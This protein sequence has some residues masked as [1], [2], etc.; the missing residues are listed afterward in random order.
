LIRKRLG[1][2][3]G[4]LVLWY[5]SVLAVVLLAI[6]VTQALTLS[7]YLRS[8]TA[9][10]MRQAAYAELRALT[11]CFVRSAAD[12]NRRAQSLATLLGSHE[13]AV[14]IVTPTGETLADHSFG[15][16]NALHPLTLSA[17]T[18]T[19]LIGSPPS[20]KTVSCSTAAGSGT[21]G[22][23]PGSRPEPAVLSQGSLV[24]TSVSIGPFSHP[25]GYALLGRS[26]AA[27]QET[28][29]RTELVFGLGALSAIVLAALVALPLI[30]R[31]LRPLRRVA[32]TAA[33]IAAGDLGQ[34][35]NLARSPDEIGR[36]G[37]AFDTMVDRL[38]DALTEANESEE[39]MRRFLAD[40]S[41]EL[42]TP[43][44]VL[45][46]TSEVLLRHRAGDPELVA[47]L[48][49]MNEDA[50]RLSKLVDDLLT[51]TRL[52]AGQPLNPEAIP[53]RSF[54]EDFA[55]RY[56]IAWPE[57]QISLDLEGFDGA[58][59]YVDPEVLRR[60]VTNLVDN[61][62]R[63]SRP[64]GPITL[65]GTAN[66]QGVIVAVH[67]EGP[68]LTPEDATRVF[69]RFYRSA[70]SRSRNT[71]G[72]GL[73]LSIVQAL[74]KQSGGS[75]DLE[76]RRGQGTTFSVTLPRQRRTGSKE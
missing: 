41:H 67:D 48:K 64:G 27:G 55:D 71:G 43:M 33:A 42:R 68:G 34:R 47:A 76:T 35:A 7:D 29:N 38:Q 46:G 60:M 44:T 39:R 3:R 73:G 28:L 75:V 53:V 22:L 8:T 2:I 19:Q 30:N 18:I 72:T 65:G 4:K 9:Q 56:S 52:D 32:D 25:Y 57:R 40:A 20:R 10:A 66:P 37:A 59:A 14:K 5:L 70:R 50:V 24:L 61:A 62:A 58:S 74:A 23:P 1:S 6:G 15:P 69:E 13:T 12:L 11:P 54:L 17:T 26:F 16:P 51:L 63:Y 36:M 49:A 21:T 45:R 31:A